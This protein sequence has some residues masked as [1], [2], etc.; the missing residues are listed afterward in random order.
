LYF[1]KKILLL[2]N[3]VD[4]N[5]DDLISKKNHLLYNAFDSTSIQYILRK[6]TL[7]QKHK[8][9]KIKLKELEN[10]LKNKSRKWEKERQEKI[11]FE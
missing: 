6:R 10:F 1:F 5:A 9:T 3:K 11:Q 2:I 8:N 7:Y 4:L